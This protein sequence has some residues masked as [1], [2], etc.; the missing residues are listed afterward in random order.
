MNSSSSRSP[1]PTDSLLEETIQL[2]DDAAHTKERLNGFCT[3]FQKWIQ[4]MEDL[5]MLPPSKELDALRAW[6]S[7]A[8]YA[9]RTPRNS[10]KG[11]LV[12]RGQGFGKK[13]AIV[14]TR[15]VVLDPPNM[16]YYLDETQTTLK[17][18]LYLDR[19]KYTREGDWF[20]IFNGN[21]SDDDWINPLNKSK[22]KY[23]WSIP[24]KDK[25]EAKD[26]MKMWHESI[27]SAMK[28]SRALRK[29]LILQKQFSSVKSASAYYEL[30]QSLVESKSRRTSSSTSSSSSSSTAASSSWH[31]QIPISWL[32]NHKHDAEMTLQDERNRG[33]RNDTGFVQ[34]TSFDRRRM[35]TRTLDDVKLQ[36]LHS[37]LAFVQDSRKFRC[38]VTSMR[39]VRKDMPRD[40]IVI[41]GVPYVGTSGNSAV[42]LVF[43]CIMKVLAKRGG[44][45]EELKSS[46]SR[47]GGIR[48]STRGGVTTAMMTAAKKKHTVNPHDR[49]RALR[50]AR[51]VVL[52]SS[53]TISGG[54]TWDAA[55]FLCRNRDVAMMIPRSD[56]ASP[57][58][59]IVKSY[60]ADLAQ[61]CK[62][63]L[64]GFPYVLVWTDM[65][66][67]IRMMPP[68]QSTGAD[69]RVEI[70]RIKT[71]FQR[72]FVS[73]NDGRSDSLESNFPDMSDETD[74]QRRKDT[75]RKHAYRPT[76]LQTF[77]VF[78]QGI[79]ALEVVANLSG[80][81][82]KSVGRVR[83]AGAGDEAKEL[84]ASLS[85]IDCTADASE[86]RTLER[87]RDASA[88]RSMSGNAL[89]GQFRAST[90]EGTPDSSDTAAK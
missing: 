76:S 39:Q 18:I 65:W 89:V 67:S 7:S 81:A 15:W 27:T 60:S 30:L 77:D 40:T 46:S 53:R 12:K 69:L 63:A 38:S 28:A 68:P 48:S 9:L 56:I 26:L 25:Y 75:W 8:S 54:E 74:M 43:R 79:V 90:V 52:G 62:S 64:K 32:R 70:A 14:Q 42:G 58:N 35:S 22:L 61:S 82:R 88:G 23:T 66:Y 6:T 59:V 11:W 21:T 36:N 34:S 87:F 13:L 3:A 45:N 57:I 17:G 86:N 24:P 19:C 16:L 20:T 72:K 49:L 71:R 2:L 50:L 5:K 47:G 83:R 1:A 29:L 84:S 33:T 37:Q 55:D 73:H 10:I 4:N 44:G 78:D 85:R 51:R 31:F 41:N 80:E